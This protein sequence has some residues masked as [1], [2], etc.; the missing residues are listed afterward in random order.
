M[1]L[2]SLSCSSSEGFVLPFAGKSRTRAN[3]SPGALV[4]FHP[5][6]KADPK[7]VSSV[8]LTKEDG[9]FTLTTGD[10]VGVPAGEY[11]IT[12]ICSEKVSTKKGVISTG[13]AETQDRLNGVYS[14][15][16]TSQIVV[17]VKAGENQLD[18][19]DLEVSTTSSARRRGTPLAFTPFPHKSCGCTWRR[20]T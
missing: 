17:T 1:S 19:F 11:V 16:D 8:G 14:N 18:P 20:A 3:R 2:I 7:T 4:A 9:T 5:K 13:P 10:K 15:R 12:I 6:G